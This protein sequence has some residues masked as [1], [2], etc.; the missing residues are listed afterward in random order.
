M[1]PETGFTKGQV[2]D[3]YTRVSRWLLP[4]LKDRPITRIRISE[5]RRNASISSRK[6]RRRSRP[7]GSRPSPCRAPSV[8]ATTPLHYYQRP[9]DA[10]LAREHGDA[11][12]H[13]L[14]ARAPR[15]DQP[16]MVVFDLD[17]GRG[18][19]DSRRVR[20]RAQDPRACW[21]IEAQ[22]VSSRS[23]ARRASISTCRSTAARTYAATQPFASRSPRRSSADHPISWSRRWRR[24]CARAR[25]FVDWSQNTERKS[26]VAVY[27]LRAKHGRPYVAQPITWEELKKALKRGDPDALFLEPEECLRR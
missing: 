3:Y 19:D 17:P 6:T 18:D 4:H 16:T 24:S 23:R 13:P 20:D 21:A 25:S 2:I 9:R 26:T 7:S 22:V 15:L 10:G 12:I 5:R 14:L 11:R 27:S 1:Y 8:E